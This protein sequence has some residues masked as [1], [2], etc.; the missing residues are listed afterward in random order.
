MRKKIEYKRKTKLKETFSNSFLLIALIVI[1]VIFG[2]LAPGFLSLNNIL[3]L[4]A[5]SSIIGILACGNMILMAAGEMSFSVGAQCT[6]TG[7]LFG[8]LLSGTT[9][10]IGLAFLL[11]MAFSVLIGFVLAFFSVRVGV[12]TFVLTLAV[13]TILD[14]FIQL[15]TGGTTLYSPAWP[16]NFTL[17]QYK[18][19]DTL[20][21]PVIVF[22]V[23]AV[24][25]DLYYERTRFGRRI[26]A[27]GANQTA[28]RNVGI[29]VPLIKTLVFAIS[30]AYF[31]FAGIVSASYNNNISITFGTG[32]LLPAITATMLSATFIRIGSYNV[33]GTALAS[34][35]MIVIQ[36]GVIS[37]GYPIYV[38]DIVQGLLLT[39]A[40]AIIALT[41]ESGL[42]SVRLDS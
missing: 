36:N 40:V 9:N 19:F 34:V 27:T 17:M 22:F 5:L 16:D 42:P 25:T 1:S 41:K 21:L 3:N 38:K 7:A 4:F 2:I 20:P 39:V 10:S 15:F 31:G 8:L 37:T 32:L 13:G 26:N 23:I 12:P 11:A 30:G 18:A 29:K 35:L 14:G 6:A 28:A 33:P 24:F